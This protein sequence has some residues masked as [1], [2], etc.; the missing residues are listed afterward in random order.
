M[1]E[2]YDISKIFHCTLTRKI[3]K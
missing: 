2:K 3:K 1:I